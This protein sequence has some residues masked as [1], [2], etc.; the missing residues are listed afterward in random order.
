VRA[1]AAEIGAA[2]FGVGEGELGAARGHAAA[3]QLL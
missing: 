1:G 3:H 2:D